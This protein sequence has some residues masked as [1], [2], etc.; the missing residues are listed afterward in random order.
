MQPP[1]SPPASCS[2]E[3]GETQGTK[4]G[5]LDGEGTGPFWEAGARGLGAVQE[6][7]QSANYPWDL[8]PVKDNE[9]QLEICPYT[10]SAE[11]LGAPENPRRGILEASRTTALLH[12]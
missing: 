5:E 10:P 2:P 9:S 1:P 8:Y 4:H 6:E 7:G 3:R 12:E 11:C